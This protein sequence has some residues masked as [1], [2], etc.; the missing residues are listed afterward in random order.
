M[1]EMIRNPILPGFH[2]DPS[3]CRV[4]GDFYIANSTFEWFPG[5]RI[6]HSRDLAHWRLVGGALDRPGQLDMVGNPDSGGVWAPQLSWADGQFWLI[7]TNVR[8]VDPGYKDTPNFLVTA[9]TIEG[10]WSEPVY[11]NSSGFDPSLFHDQ[12]GRKWLV[13]MWWDHR[14]GHNR[15]GGILLQE[16]SVRQQKLIGP[17]RN[18]HQGTELGCTE[19]PHLL[20]HD[21]WYYLLLAEGGTGWNHAETIARSRKIEGPYETDPAFP[22]LTSRGKSC[23]LQKAGHASLTDTPDGKWYMVHLASRPIGTDRRCMLGRETAIQQVYWTDDGWLRLLEGSSDPAD[24]VA[25]P[26]LPAFQPAEPPG[27]DDFDGP[28]LSAHLNS[29]RVPVDASWLGLTDRPGWLRLI[30]RESLISRH[31]QSLVARRV[32]DFT[33][34]ARTKM[35]FAPESPQQMAGLVAIYNTRM[36][37]Y[38]HV[39]WDEALGRCLRLEVCDN[40]KHAASAEPIG[41][42]DGPIWLE[43]QIR[44]G[45]LQFGFSAD[46]RTFDSFGQ[47]L[48]ATKLSDDY[49]SGWGFTGA[50]VGLCCQDL[51]AGARAADFDFF[52]VL[53]GDRAA[54][55]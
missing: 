8:S 13:N 54:E 31:R 20:K 25:A 55:E 33:C 53:H 35:E 10:P 37:Y 19:G 18:I 29:L 17:V 49:V 52:E 27:R 26:D 30:G 5:V 14:P 40:G 34:R 6:H 32:E 43:A 7:Y 50:F 9:E 22:M 1:P 28:A 46:G 11:L 48:D 39:S 16:Y 51:S 47:A 23:R 38:L 42:D 15:F 12:D 44:S 24:Q 2:P 4:G 41:I 3:I 21:G 36:W 45:Q